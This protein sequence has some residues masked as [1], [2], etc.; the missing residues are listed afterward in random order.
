MFWIERFAVHDGPGIRVAVFLK[1]CPLRCGWCHSPESQSPEPELL[2]KSDR[3][4]VCGTCLPTCDRKAIRQT[5][6]GFETLRDYCDACGVC[7]DACPSGARTIAGR[8]MSV[9]DLMREI[10]KDRVFVDRSSGG[11][12]FS[13]GEPLMQPAFLAEALTA[14]RASGLHTAIETSG[15]ASD[16]AMDVAARADLILFDLKLYDEERHRQ[17]TGVSNRVILRN[18]ARVAAGRTPVRI[19]IPL[20]PGVNDD[21]E[22]LEAL[23][24]VAASAGITTVDVL[25]YHTAGIAKYQRLNRTYVL[26]DVVPPRPDALVAARQDL[27]RCGLVVSLGG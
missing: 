27:E 19:R 11:V 12:T 17:A 6:D 13:G 20:I 14:C 1:G 26:P 5:A 4:I 22:N 23:G 9:P 2:V 8:V 7:V 15:F 24:R 3:C 10:E 16:F 18:F 21:G 25:P